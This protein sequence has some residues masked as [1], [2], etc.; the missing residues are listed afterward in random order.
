[1][2][3]RK[4]DKELSKSEIRKQ[5]EKEREINQANLAK[6]EEERQLKLAMK[7]KQRQDLIDGLELEINAKKTNLSKEQ[8]INEE[9]KKNIEKHENIRSER[10]KK[11]IL[12]RKNKMNNRNRMSSKVFSKRLIINYI[13]IY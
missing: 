10:N 12:D 3:K 13:F 9:I 11:E 5:N 4:Q 7:H 8:E 2:I 6:W 1:M